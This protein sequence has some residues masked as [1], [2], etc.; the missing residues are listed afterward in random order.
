LKIIENQKLERGKFV[1]EEVVFI[2]CEVIECDLFYSGGDFEWTN[3]TFRSCRFH[4]RGPAANTRSLIFMMKIQPVQE[5]QL[6][7]PMTSSIN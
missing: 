7:D 1:L 2:N 5:P 4:F 3:T 6:P